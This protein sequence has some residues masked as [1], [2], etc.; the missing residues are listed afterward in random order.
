MPL[1]RVLSLPWREEARHEVIVSR[2]TCNEERR[3]QK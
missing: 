3:E 1:K 2:K